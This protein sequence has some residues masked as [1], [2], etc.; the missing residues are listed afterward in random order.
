MHP[1]TILTAVL[2]CASIAV[3]LLLVGGLPTSVVTAQVDQSPL[4]FSEA[5]GF[6]AQ[7]KTVGESDVALLKTYRQEIGEGDYARGVHDRCEG[8]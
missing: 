4:T 5:I 3:C 2:L 6:F 7:E 8:A 1:R